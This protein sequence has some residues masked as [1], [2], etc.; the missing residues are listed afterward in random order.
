MVEQRAYAPEQQFSAGEIA[1]DMAEL[2][3]MDWSKIGIGDVPT[4]N[5]PEGWPVS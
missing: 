4:N 1:E 5:D 2:M 3:T